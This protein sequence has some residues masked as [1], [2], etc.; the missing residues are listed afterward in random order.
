L[1]DHDPVYKKSGVGKILVYSVKSFL[2]MLLGAES[3]DNRNAVQ[4]FP[5]YSVQSVNQILYHPEFGKYNRN[6]GGY[7]QYQDDHG[8]DD[9]PAHCG[10]L[11]YRHDNS[12]DSKY[13]GVKTHAYPHHKD[14][15]Y[16]AD[17]VG[18]AGNERGRGE[19]VELI[20]GKAFY[21]PEKLQAKI[22]SNPRGYPR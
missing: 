4:G 5:A 14:L 1:K 6:K 16:L 13:W 19:L 22:P 15:L 8:E 9:N 2:C 20:T 10:S 18:T 11:V 17:I 3:P 12:P 21:L 7:K